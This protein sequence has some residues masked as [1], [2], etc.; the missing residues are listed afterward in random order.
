MVKRYD[1]DPLK[2]S[3][4]SAEE[5]GKIEVYLEMNISISEISKRINRSKSTV[6]EEIRR[7]KYNGRY[8]AEIAQNRCKKR[9]CNS[10]KYTKW[11][12]PALLRFIEQNLKKRWSPE[13]ISIK[14]KEKTGRSF[15][16]T[17]IYTLIK[18]HRPEWKKWL[19]YGKKRRRSDSSQSFAGK[20]PDRVSISERPGEVNLRQR[21]GDYEADT[22]L[23][24]KGVKACLAVFVERKSRMYFFA[25]MKN[26][27]SEEMFS[28]T[29]KTLKDKGVKTMT[30][31]NG[32]ENAKHKEI[33][34]ELGCKSFF[35]N[36]YHGWEKGSIENRNKILRQFFP[37]G[38]NFGLIPDDEIYKIQEIINNRPMKLLNWRSPPDV[39]S[40][41][42]SGY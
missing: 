27:T 21:F 15:S 23:S 11:R 19:I 40:S 9:R 34:E 16:H 6:S 32:T 42:C 28:V 36:A 25:K 2:Y 3:Q 41:L 5:R 22:V 10:H 26:K 4:L 14:W 24:S 38:T 7:G 31:D 20:I 35:C 17:S 13:I 8:R 37:K 1:K 18:K 30:Y 33:N 39:F 12:D 29:V